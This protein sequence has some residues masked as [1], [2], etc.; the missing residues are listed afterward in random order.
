MSKSLSRKK[1][2]GTAIL[3]ISHKEELDDF[4]KISIQQCLSILGKHDTY[5]ILPQG[6][7]ADNYK[8][9]SPN[10]KFDFIPPHWQRDYEWFNKLKVLPFLY[11][12]YKN[13][14]HILFYEPDAFVFKDDLDFWCSTEYD[15]IG[16]PWFKKFSNDT[17]KHDF[18]GVGNGGFSLRRIASHLKVLNSYSYIHPIDELS[19]LLLKNKSPLQK[20][21]AIPSFIRNLTVSNNT[22]YLM[23]NFSGHEDQFWGLVASRNFEWFTVP[24]PII[25]SQ[26]AFEMK[27]SVLFELNNHQLPFGCH[28]W[29]KYDLAFWK[30]HIEKFGYTINIGTSS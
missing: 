8:I 17:D 11:E 7:K 25:A 28:A 29:W 21:K 12:R 4:E 1:N 6:L 5:F 15:Y 13:Y 27:P 10:A 9:Y 2:G 14:E 16:A 26:F 20:I 18:L 22:H 30:P 24:S 3:I 19:E 23:N